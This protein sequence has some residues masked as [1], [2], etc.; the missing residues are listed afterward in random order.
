MIDQSSNIVIVGAGCFGLSTAYHLLKREFT[1]ITVLDS[2]HILPALEAASTDINKIVRS[3]YADPFYA[4]FARDAIAAW[5]NDKEWGDTYHESGVI[6][7]LAGTGSYADQA[8]VNDIKLGA[9]IEPLKNAEELRSAFAPGVVTASFEGRTGYLNR[10]GGWTYAT[11]GIT[12]MMDK[13]TKLG[14]RILPG[15]AVTCLVGADGRTTGVECSD[16][17][18]YSAD[19]VVLSAGS[20]TASSFPSLHLGEKCLATGQTIGKIQL[21]SE[22]ADVYR[23]NPVYMDLPTGFYIFPPNDENV[24][25]CAIHARGYTHMQPTVAGPVSQP[26]FVKGNR[27]AENLVP[28]AA[29]Q[30]L[31]DSL[32]S[33]YPELGAKPW[34][35]TRMCW[36]TDSPDEDWVI[37][38]HPADPNVMLAT[39]GSGHALK[40]LPVIGQ[41]VADAIQGILKPELVEKFAFARQKNDVTPSRPGHEI[42]ELNFDE[43]CS[44]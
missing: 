9:R 27:G 39:S 3:S 42:R 33:V 26:V 22:E 8:Y 18:V 11:Q 23:A 32:C 28:R 4:Q 2:S 43:L 41:L 34:S 14:G 31:R 17:T 35:S 10:D 1:H 15:K 36:Y 38:F 37:G 5:K 44:Q 20:W 29:L 7:L 24:V 6:V 12:L 21:T 19:L 30:E 16:G 40:F 25:K 13:V